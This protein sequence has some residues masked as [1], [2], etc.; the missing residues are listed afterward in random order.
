MG[1]G[2][3]VSNDIDDELVDID[4]FIDSDESSDEFDFLASIEKSTKTKTKRNKS[5]KR[6]LLDMQESDDWQDPEDDIMYGFKE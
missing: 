3:N 5:K 6:S 1:R 2:R 4:D